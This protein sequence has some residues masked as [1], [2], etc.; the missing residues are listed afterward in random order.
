MQLIINGAKQ[1]V[2]A[3][4]L[5]ALFAELKMNPQTVV[6]EKND[7]IIPRGENCVLQGGDKLEIVRFVGGG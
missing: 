2:S 5:S 6:V 4:D 3:H 7:A 1:N